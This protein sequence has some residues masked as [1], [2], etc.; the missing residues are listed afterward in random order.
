[1]NIPQDNEKLKQAYKQITSSSKGF[2]YSEDEFIKN[3]QDSNSAKK[4][5]NY[6]LDKGNLKLLNAADEEAFL[7]MVYP[8]PKEEKPK[9]ADVAPQSVGLKNYNK[10]FE[11]IQ[12]AIPSMQSKIEAPKAEISDTLDMN[13]NKTG[14]DFMKSDANPNEQILG[15]NT[16]SDESR[17]IKQAQM[18]GEDVVMDE[19]VADAMMVDVQN[20]LK[21]LN[22][23]SRE[24]MEEYEKRLRE[25]NA[26]NTSNHEAWNPMSY[27]KYKKL[28]EQQEAEGDYFKANGEK[29]REL[30]N[31]KKALNAQL[32]MLKSYKQLA[33]VDSSIAKAEQLSAMVENGEIS[34][35]TM[36]YL[37]GALRED[38]KQLHISMLERNGEITKE[39]AD[40]L[41]AL[42]DC[43]DKATMLQGMF[44]TGQVKDIA[45]LGASEIARVMDVAGIMSR[46]KEGVPVSDEE[47]SAAIIYSKLMQLQDADHA[48]KRDWQFG[49]G[50]MMQKSLLF[51]VEAALTGGFS[52]FGKQ[53]GAKGVKAMIEKFTAEGAKHATAKAIGQVAKETVKRAGQNFVRQGFYANITPTTYVDFANRIAGQHFETNEQLTV[54]DYAKN[55]YLSWASTTAERFSETLFNILD[56]V[57]LATL[58]TK[59]KATKGLMAHMFPA[60]GRLADSDKFK[61]ANAMLK[62]VGVQP[63]ILEEMASEASSVYMDYMLSGFDSKK[64]E[65]LGWGF[66]GQVA[67]QSIMMA[68]MGSV[69]QYTFGGADAVFENK[70]HQ[71]AFNDS[72]ALMEALPFSDYALNRLKADLRNAI[73][74]ERYVADE[75]ST[76][77]TVSDILMEMDQLITQSGNNKQD[78]AILGVVSNAAKNGAY[79]YGQMQAIK[80]Y[81]ESKIGEFEH[82]DG[83]VY[84]VTDAQGNNYFMLDNTDDVV[85]LRNKATGE[86]VTMRKDHFTEGSITQTNASD[87]AFNTLLMNADAWNAQ[88]QQ[89]APTD[90]TATELMIN[91]V[92]FPVK[93]Y[94]AQSGTY[95]VANPTT[96][97]EMTVNPND[98]DV[99][100]LF[101]EAP[102]TEQ[103]QT[104]QTEQT[105]Q[106][107]EVEQGDETEQM[108]ETA[109]ED[110]QDEQDEQEED[111]V[112]QMQYDEEGEPI[113]ESASVERGKQVVDDLFGEDEAM[114]FVNDKIKEAEKAVEAAEK[115][116]PKSTKPSERVK[117][118]ANIK[119]AKET[120]QKAYDYWTKMAK[121]Y[122][123]PQQTGQGEV[124]LVDDTRDT[125]ADA[126]A[127]GFRVVNGVRY[128][129]QTEMKSAKYGNEV[130]TKFADGVSAKGKRAVVN[131][132]ELQP[133]HIDG[134][135]NLNFFLDDAQPKDR[136]DKVSRKK[137]NDIAK[138][139]RMEE[140][141]GGVTAYTGSPSVNGVGEAIQGNNRL[142]ALKLMYEKYP[143]QAARYK[144]YL[145]EHAAEWG[146]NPDEIASMEAPILVNVL[147]VTDEQAI[148][149]GQKTAQDTESGGEHHISAPN[150]AQS[151]GKDMKVLASILF[152]TED[153]DISLDDLIEQNGYDAL[154]WLVAKKILTP[155]QL[156]TAMDE[157]QNLTPR[158][159]EALKDILTQ[160]I[161]QGGNNNIRKQFK[162]LP[163]AAQKALMQTIARELDS[164]EGEGILEYIQEA[165]E[166]YSS[167]MNDPDFKSARGEQAI[168]NAAELWARQMQMDF[169]EG[170]FVPEDRY[171]NFAIALAVT[172]KSK[173]MKEQAAMLNELY[174]YLQAEGGDIF[175]PAVKLSKEDAVKK[176]YGVE[177]NKQKNNETNEESGNGVLETDSEQ[178]STGRQVSAESD[179]DGGQHQQDL[180]ET[181]TRGADE[182]SQEE[183]QVEETETEQ[184][185][186]ETPTEPDLFQQEEQVDETHAEKAEEKTDE[187]PV[188][189]VKEPEKIEVTAELI[190]SLPIDEVMK[191]LAKQYLNG[192]VN[193]VTTKAF[194]AVDDYVQNELRNG[195]A[196][197]T[198]ADTTQLGSSAD[199]ASVQGV[200][201][202]GGQSGPMDRGQSDGDV[203]SERPSGE[204]SEGGLFDVSGEGSDNGVEQPT[205]DEPT[206]GTT[207]RSNGSR[208]GG[209]RGDVRK[210]ARPRGSN[211]VSAEAGQQGD[212]TQSIEDKIK[213]A[214]D[215]L[216]E[217]LAEISD[218]IKGSMGKLG[219]MGSPDMFKLIPPIAK[220]GY[221]LTKKGFYTF[222]KWFSQ[223]QEKL[224]PLLRN[225]FT[226]E[227]IDEL[228]RDMW[229]TEFTFNGETHTVQEWASI[230]EQE[231]LRKMIKMSLEAYKNGLISEDSPLYQACK[232][233]T[234][235]YNAIKDDPRFVS[236]IKGDNGIDAANNEYGLTDI[237]EMMAELANPAF[238]AALKAKK[239][240]RQ[241]INGIKRILGME[242]PGIESEQTDALNVL[243][244]ALDVLLDHLDVNTFN[245][246]RSSGLFAKME[247][248]R[249]LESNDEIANKYVNNV[250][251]DSSK[252]DLPKDRASALEAVKKMVKPFINKDQNKE[253]IVSN[254][255]V[256]HSATQDK[257]HEFYDVK[258]I[259]VLDKI[260]KNAV[261]IGNI[262]VSP[263]EI[264]KTHKVE[265]YYC[266]VK[267]DDKQFSV[268]LVVK[269]YENRGNILDDFQMYDLAA[270]Q[271]KS[272]VLSQGT[273][274]NS[275]TPLL[276]SDSQ[277]KV[278]DLIH[279]LQEQDKKVIGIS[280]NT[281]Y[282]QSSTPIEARQ[283]SQEVMKTNVD[284]LAD[285]L[286]V[287]PEYVYDEKNTKDKGWY[288][289]KDGKVYINLAAHATIEDARQT[290]LHEVVGHFGLR[291]LLKDKFEV[292]MQKV[293]DS[294]PKEIQDKFLS[295]YGNKEK[296]AEE[297]LSQMAEMNGEPN[298]VS[299]VMGVIRD[300]LRAIG[301]NVGNFTNGNLQYLLWRS[302]NNLRKNAGHIEAARWGAKDLEVRRRTY[303]RPAGYATN[304]LEMTAWDKFLEKYQNR[305]RP[306]KVMVDEIERR[307]GKVKESSDVYQQE[308]LSTSRAGDEMSY[309]HLNKVVPM[310]DAFVNAMRVLGDKL[311]MLG[312]DAE[313]AVYN[314]LFAKHA[315]ERNRKIC[316]GEMI[317]AAKKAIAPDKAALVNADF[318][319]ELE[320][321]A[322][323][324]YDNQFAGG[325][326]IITPQNVSADQA[327]LLITLAGVLAKEAK[328]IDSFYAKDA[329]GNKVHVGNNRSGMSDKEAKDVMDRLYNADT[330]AAFD[331]LSEKVKEC[332]DFTLDK[333]LE[334]ELISKEEYD[335]YKS[336]YKYYIPLRG[337]EEKGDDT[338]YSQVPRQRMNSGGLLNL[339]RQAK[340]RWSRAENPIAYIQSMAQSACVTGNRNL[341]RRKAFNLILENQGVGISDL[342]NFEYWYQVKD[343]DGN[344]GEPT[345][346]APSQDLFDKGLVKQIPDK[347]YLWHKT[348]D[349][350]NCHEIVVM[351]NGR[352]HSFFMH[353]TIG[354]Q[355]ATAING[356]FNDTM[357]IITQGVAPFT[358]FI[359]SNLTAKNIY[360]LGK[361][362]VRDLGFGNFAYFVENG[363][364]KTMQLN[365]N[366]ISAMRTA[367]M[368]AMHADP[369]S[370]K[371][372]DLYQE[373]K[374]E[375]GQT[376]YVQLHEIEKLTKD[377][378]KMIKEATANDGVVVSGVKNTGK[379]IADTFDV[380][381]KA[382]ENA[383]RFAVYKTERQNGA[384]PREAAIRAKEITV[385]FNKQGR[386]T[387]GLSAWFAFFNP[388]V[389]GAYR[390]AKLAKEH[391]GRFVMATASLMALKF[392]MGVICEMFGGDDDEEKIKGESAYDRLSDYVK[393][394]NW[395]IPLSWMGEEQ[396]GKFLCIPLPQ[397]VRASTYWA[398][399]AVDMLF[400]KKNFS[401]VVWDASLFAAGEFLPV[402][403]DALDFKGNKFWQSFVQMLTPTVARPVIEAY[404][405]NRDFMGNPI[406]KEPYLRKENKA[407][408]HSLAFSSTSPF[409]VGTSKFLNEL[410]GGTEYRSAKWQY[411][412]NG[413]IEESALR[414]F[415]DINPAKLEHLFSG[416]FGGMFK[417][418]MDTWDIMTSGLDEDREFEMKSMPIVNQFIKG[419]TSPVG[420]KTYYRMRD[421]ANNLI[422][423]ESI[424]EAVYSDDWKALKS[425][426]YNA[427]IVI[428]Y[429][430]YSDQVKNI[431][432]M[433]QLSRKSNSEKITDVIKNLEEKRD[434]LILEA[435]KI[436]RDICERRD[437]DN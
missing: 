397:S 204:S 50:Q 339:N 58:L 43:T 437:K 160:V 66:F 74:S 245:R 122:E 161:F 133:S 49:F 18:L 77:K 172:F 130:E 136:T 342:A 59:G 232:D 70:K 335:E 416:Y 382:S 79:R 398:D 282:R 307:G 405:L 214:D 166:V 34:Q 319:K 235:V 310:K 90:G 421:E 251:V 152:R 242:I 145:V 135:R 338:D 297:Y 62:S 118:I 368:D 46:I 431:N 247:F 199:D 99:E 3:M 388:A 279:N 354:A 365:G 380:L 257:S 336:Q 148:A 325:R 419:P 149:L 351:I 168:M 228:I 180:G 291:G 275:L 367:A 403:I 91:G 385:N 176:V 250:I 427:E 266:P 44:K 64:L 337:W 360:F 435:A 370:I 75:K 344:W 23:G 428:A 327:K 2:K 264:G 267:I 16:F 60:L 94:N 353:G 69:V 341:I 241:L 89:Q 238:R 55:Y 112:D 390:Y 131:A 286:G 394:T 20:Q 420:Y 65:E 271:K 386:K 311:G 225:Y 129:R 109:E 221:A 375:G 399:N 156:Q 422:D 52:G 142:D 423:C 195:T 348:K 19:Q 316:L 38:V 98:A 411:S 188:E 31:R 384:T 120:A 143:E 263:D 121:L 39:T 106:A 26:Y 362:V 48:D 432:E 88:A 47:K 346:I 115:L 246:Y 243:E 92:R 72:M 73:T 278:R 95:T 125:P 350:K 110:T 103:Q 167:L 144:Q 229:D 389:Q 248:N 430:A 404:V 313:R 434:K 236:L 417:P 381:G 40:K 169:T 4:L 104:E 413:Q 401:E 378:E 260:I 376:G 415:M 314:Y 309:F 198:D 372:Y 216:N 175:N 249:Q 215:L 280:E 377:F 293:F 409:L 436:Y 157:K 369:A 163:K 324:I 141:T 262:P 277:Y 283:H 270:K 273:G 358:R 84:E 329:N 237:H 239:L 299:K 222:T 227:E 187:T 184:E 317:E 171:S 117:E 240:W 407:P 302:K 87:W 12:D 259:G 223:M 108:E 83:N 274:D 35:S 323:E 396:K 42:G 343:E 272:D 315:P 321:I 357:S 170:N 124:A 255:A 200:G 374:R 179:T 63:N 190:D 252:I 306:V 196:D 76:Y 28:K 153:E 285:V 36:S 193:S 226:I 191:S 138:N 333:W 363:M 288:D 298:L 424:E 371:D 56:D 322:G 304:T 392:G 318:L 340:G 203:S 412:Q 1:M 308:F 391:P 332:T 359:S 140:I 253:I 355:S 57:P 364:H 233:I 194:K 244:N 212:R 134:N 181:D 197:S 202:D 21:A 186:E 177:L 9:E 256:R 217:G 8:K 234:E 230:V 330:Q 54:G 37:R 81:V 7:E 22:E 11:A 25:A 93:S 208:S 100:E 220:V 352:K 86:K 123:A 14:L 33:E 383:M 102:Q 213:S 185:A 289:P 126:R 292:T 305:M 150:V 295:K 347:G 71:N 173:T 13:L 425:N 113:W 78:R 139:P 10:G 219:S 312:E 408:Q 361:N 119:A 210:P 287:A 192:K 17:F 107:E 127:R 183:Q 45:T 345:P 426:K 356:S 258:C 15:G 29:Y 207:G 30:Q 284:E 320:R 326:N 32:D 414:N 261:K 165:I 393:A 68:G 174:D 379:F 61:A 269:Q 400:G 114:P 290:Y 281:L 53:L 151:L 300:A 85:V 159:K 189:E 205:S 128:D 211:G 402:D 201:T 231:E 331:E 209:K 410:A 406:S 82:N 373:F 147:D 328:T 137:A 67:L 178:G 387:K 303:G 429:K 301:I 154:K 164:A 254:K 41:L 162:M 105:E 268:R 433:I 418:V 111:Q 132:N 24:F 97:E 146:L 206:D 334:Y 395:V 366:Y 6:M 158:A 294:L 27:S 296:A 101:S 224:G 349:E 276:T 80:S 96:G 5:Y 155:T 218:I 265:I 51:V 116:K 182:S